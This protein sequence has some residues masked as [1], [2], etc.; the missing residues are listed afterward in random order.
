M[1]TSHDT[2]LPGHHKADN[3]F[4]H[5]GEA[6]R[7]KELVVV[8]QVEGSYYP[9]Q[10]DR[11]FQSSRGLDCSGLIIQYDLYKNTGIF[12]GFTNLELIGF[13]V[14]MVCLVAGCVN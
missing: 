6:R 10:R 1:A 11:N 14:P 5:R 3:D 12:N 7:R 2:A 4:Q 9:L 8:L 13:K